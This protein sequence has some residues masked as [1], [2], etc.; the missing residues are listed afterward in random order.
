MF[1][2]GDKVVICRA[3]PGGGDQT[4]GNGVVQSVSVR[5]VKLADGSRWRSNGYIWGCRSERGVGLG[6][7]RRIVRTEQGKS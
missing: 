3:I 6:F 5:M 4:L 7:Q 2:V 1:K